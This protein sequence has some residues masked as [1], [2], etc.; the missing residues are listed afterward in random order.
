M[1]KPKHCKTCK[2]WT[3]SKAG[4]L[5]GDC[6]SPDSP[7]RGGV[8]WKESTCDKYESNDKQRDLELDAT[9]GKPD[10]DVR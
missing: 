4:P 2:W 9:D 8:T 7:Y 1:T 6:D 10:M 5:E 3:P